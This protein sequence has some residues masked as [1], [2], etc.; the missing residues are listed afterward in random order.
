MTEPTMQ[1]Q[2]EAAQSYEGLFVPSLFGQWA[3]I[4]ADAARVQPGQRVLDVACGTGVLAREVASRVGSNGFTA[5]L[6]PAPGMLAVAKQLAPSVEWKEGTAELL[7]FEDRSFDAVVS[8]FGLMFFP[9]R[10]QAIAEM[11]RVMVPGGRLA[12]AV[13]DSLEN[14]P[15]YAAEVELFERF[16]GPQAADALRAPF[17]LGDRDELVALFVDAGAASV[18]VKTCLGTASFPGIRI[19]VEA[20]LR[21]WLPVMGVVL[22]EEQIQQILGEAEQVLSPYV[23]ERQDA[24]FELAALIVTGTKP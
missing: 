14:I 12:V 10:P 24:T 20:D 19:M 7:P 17:V 8:Q 6:D 18:E 13:F 9:D 11:L 22:P 15:A 2:I 3:P 1:S 23:G 5:G 16:A 4:V 21:G